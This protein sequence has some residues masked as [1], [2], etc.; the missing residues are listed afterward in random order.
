VKRGR[1]VKT[2]RRVKRKRKG[3]VRNE[4]GEIE[5]RGK[6]SFMSV[7]CISKHID[8]RTPLRVFNRVEIWH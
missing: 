8:N 5:E 2:G 3:E 6:A 1:R 4:S 7:I